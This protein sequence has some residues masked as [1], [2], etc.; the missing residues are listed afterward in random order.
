MF[1]YRVYGLRV[2][3][4]F[5]LPELTPSEFT[6]PDVVIRAGSVPEPLSDS[7]SSGIL[8]QASPG[9]FRLAL[10]GIATFWVRDGREIV[11][12][13]DSD[14][15]ADSVRV[16]LLGSAFGA[17]LHQRGL[18]PL[19]ASAIRVQGNIV[20][21]A[22]ASGIGKST[23]AAAFSRDG[24]P[25]VAD[26]VLVVSTDAARRAVGWAA[27]PQL[28][29]WADVVQRIHPGSSGFRKVRR[30]VQRFAVPVVGSDVEA[31]LPLTR[32]YVVC[33]SDDDRFSLEPLTGSAKLQALLENTYRVQYLEGLGRQPDHFRLCAQLGRSISVRRLS[34]PRKT[35]DLQRLQQLIEEDWRD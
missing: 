21:F 23:L 15:E 26:D 17:L 29:L 10:D 33:L 5:E 2:E 22:G 35:F 4:E 16:F 3:S 30:S 25:V 27:Y 19:H 13:R 12:D 32:L 28:K 11:V 20:A 24:H 18:L 14:S 1:R 6:T 31:P 8:Y 9:E 34:R 7:R